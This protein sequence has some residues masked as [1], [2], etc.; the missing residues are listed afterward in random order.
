LRYDA[1][2]DLLETIEHFLSRLDIYTELPPYGGYGKNYSENN[3]GTA[4]H[5][6]AHDEANQTE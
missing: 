3:G 6:R 4:F 1:L 5:H 2:I